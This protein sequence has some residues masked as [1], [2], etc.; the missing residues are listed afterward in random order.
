MTKKYRI[1]SII[2]LVATILLNVAPLTTYT[3]IG[4]AE[5][6]LVV[7]K[8]ALT[9]T[10]FVVLILT[11]YTLISKAALRSRIWILLLGLYFCLNNILTPLV[12][13]AVCQVIDELI[14]NPLLRHYR[15][16]YIINREIDKRGI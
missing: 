9:S 10:I 6:D 8:V 3:I 13:I 7:E 5:A 12:I 1:L 16:K 11:V 15:N 4:Y 14:V 2:L